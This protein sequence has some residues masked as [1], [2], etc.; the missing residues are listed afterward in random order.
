MA[1]QVSPTSSKI[2]FTPP[3]EYLATLCKKVSDSLVVAQ[4]KTSQ[5][6]QALLGFLGSFREFY[7]QEYRAEEIHL[8]TLNGTTING[9]HFHGTQ[10]KA[11]IYLHGNGYFC[12]T[13]ADKPLIWREGLKTPDGDY[14]HL[15]VCNPGGTGKSEGNTH[16]LT[17]ARDLLAQFDYLVS[18]HGVDPNAI[19]IASYS[20]GAYLGAFGA[21]FIQ[22]RYPEARINFLSERSFGSIYSRVNFWMYLPVY[23]TSWG[24]DL[25]SALE[26]LKGRVCIVYHK[27]DPV[28]PY[29]ES[30]H[31]ILVKS[32]R[33]RS[34]DCLELRDLSEDAH[35]T[36][37]KEENQKIIVELKR[38]MQ[39][40]LTKEE[41]DLTLESF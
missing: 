21:A 1:H 15:V 17:V 36:L 22:Q 28:V 33:K 26:S 2:C 7:Q 11:L 13:G 31:S 41:E 27:S 9:L 5:D 4:Q 32:E 18:Q 8:P 19:A 24:Q 35:K 37:S 40:P 30:T 10:K 34:Y 12:E 38:M 39:I 14:P 16:P 23:I 29:E 6:K 25:V 20:M 3:S